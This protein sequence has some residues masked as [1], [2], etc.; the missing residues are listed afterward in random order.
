MQCQS[1]FTPS[2]HNR[3]NAKSKIQI[4]QLLTTWTSVAKIHKTGQYFLWMIITLS[5]KNRCI[6]TT[7]IVPSNISG[8]PDKKQF[9]KWSMRTWEPSRSDRP[10]IVIAGSLKLQPRA[11]NI[12][13]HGV[14][15]YQAYQYP[16]YNRCSQSVSLYPLHMI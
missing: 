4:L 11:S 12:S 16:C 1:L 5:V 10:I 15:T 13:K 2:E 6:K 7:N 8:R 9:S 14:F 3:G